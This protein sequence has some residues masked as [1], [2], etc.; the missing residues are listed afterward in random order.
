MLIWAY[1]TWIFSEN[2]LP[3]KLFAVFANCEIQMET[4]KQCRGKEEWH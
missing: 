3:S 2:A 1:I 4:S